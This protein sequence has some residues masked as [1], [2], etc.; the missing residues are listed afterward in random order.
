MNYTNGFVFII[1][2]SCCAEIQVTFSLG[3]IAQ[4][5]T[6][7]RLLEEIIVS[8]LSRVEGVTILKET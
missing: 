2:G 3:A 8:S 4:L 6:C 7:Y 5:V 1:L